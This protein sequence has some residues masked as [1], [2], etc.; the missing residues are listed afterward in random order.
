VNII[1]SLTTIIVVIIIIC[2][3]FQ[4]DCL[5]AKVF[6]KIVKSKSRYDSPFFIAFLRTT[7]FNIGTVFDI[8]LLFLLLYSI[9]AIPQRVSGNITATI[10]TTDNITGIITFMP[11]YSFDLILVSI[12]AASFF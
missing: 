10:S 4:F 12:M 6:T 8:G 5:V 2:A 9:A 11:S 7:L 1:G 3:P